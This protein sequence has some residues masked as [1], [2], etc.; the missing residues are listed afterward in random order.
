MSLFLAVFLVAGSVT[1]HDGADGGEEPA[2]GNSH[3]YMNLTKF[4]PVSQPLARCMDGTMSGVYALPAPAPAPAPG[5]AGVAGVASQ[6]EWWVLYL[7]SGGWCYD[8]SQ[9]SI[10]YQ[11]GA[12]LWS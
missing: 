1:T 4:D 7:A 12:K 3:A 9:D 8:A 11:N 6:S 5:V 10:F 2:L